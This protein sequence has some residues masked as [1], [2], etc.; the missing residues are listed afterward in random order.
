MKL[1]VL[2]ATEYALVAAKASGG[3]V[4]KLPVLAATEYALVAAKASGGETV[5]LPVLAAT[6]YALV[7]GAPGS[8]DRARQV[9]DLI[10]EAVPRIAPIV[11]TAD[12]RPVPAVIY[13]DRQE[14][15]AATGIPSRAPIVGLATFPAGVIHVDSGG[16]LASIGKV[17][18]HEVGHVLIGRAVGPAFGALPIW[19]NE[20][21]AEYVAGERAAQVDP[22]TLQAVG[23]GEIIPL[24]ELDAA[25]G[26]GGGRGRLAYTE[27][28]S[29]VNFLVS[30]RGE[31]IIASL[32]GSLRETR[33]FEA[34]LEQETGWDVVELEKAWSRSVSRRF[35]WPLLLGSSALPFTLMLLLFLLALVRFLIERRR[36]Q[37]MAE[38]DW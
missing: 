7:A 5:K 11:G 1:P 33:D 19:L 14:F 31:Q 27:A 13:V 20:G 32:L 3:E 8:A 17:V 30:A 4:M 37:E 26:S 28:A 34:A 22:V 18:P 6:E 35:R 9:A 25:F 15:V 10:D 24:A 2:A 21:V 38:Q 23:R 36:R 16:A 12:L 29:I